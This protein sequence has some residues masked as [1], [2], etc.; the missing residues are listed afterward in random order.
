MEYNGKIEKYFNVS[1]D[2]NNLK[3]Y[4]VTINRNN[5]DLHTKVINKEKLK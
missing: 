1:I 2:R 3:C 4:T 5:K